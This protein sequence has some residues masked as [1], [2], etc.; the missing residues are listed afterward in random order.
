MTA[1]IEAALPPLGRP[2]GADGPRRLRW[3]A[4]G[5]GEVFLP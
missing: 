4:T 1:P 5:S 2:V 3:L